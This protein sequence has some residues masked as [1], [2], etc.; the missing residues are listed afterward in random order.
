MSRYLSHLA[1]L[2]LN[3]VEPLQPRLA[4]RFETPINMGP[5]ENNRL[6][7]V[8]ESQAASPTHVQPSTLNTAKSPVTHKIVTAPINVQA[9]KDCGGQNHPMVDQPTEF[10][11][12][13][14]E[15]PGGLPK[16]SPVQS[17]AAFDTKLN[18]EQ[19]TRRA[20]SVDKPVTQTSYGIRKDVLPTERTHTLVEHIQERF[21]ETTHSELVIREVALPHATQKNSSPEESPRP[22]PVKPA[23]IVVRS[24]QPTARQNTPSQTD[25]RFVQS[26]T[27]ATPTPTVQ[28]TIGR[29]EIRATQ[30][31]DKPAAKLRTANTTM[32]LEDY[33]K[34]RNGGRA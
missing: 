27:D 7:I 29:I 6:D 34:Q 1:A 20:Q 5:F 28:V 2:T 16:P 33:L 22:A 11:I 9:N 8:Q 13:K 18:T 26:A 4:S 24:E 31:T 15:S 23:S 32:S 10:I 17:M 14:P 30:I 12:N 3:R 19:S 21:T 25:V